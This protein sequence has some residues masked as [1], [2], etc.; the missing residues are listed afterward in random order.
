[1]LTKRPRTFHPGKT[2][3]ERRLRHRLSR[4]LDTA[5]KFS[6]QCIGGFKHTITER[7]TEA[8]AIDASVARIERL[9]Q[10]DE[11]TEYSR[12]RRRDTAPRSTAKRQSTRRTPSASF[13]R[14]AID[15]SL[16]LLPDLSRHRHALP[17][18]QGAE[19]LGGDFRAL[20]PLPAQRY[21]CLPQ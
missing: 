10:L 9:R 14:S 7:L 8:L 13:T 15:D 19:R 18:R 2:F 5:T 20:P 16:P 17:H 4:D 11:A 12:N 6:A 3:R 1:M 21:V